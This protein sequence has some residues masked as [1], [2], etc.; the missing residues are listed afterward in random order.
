MIL[1]IVGKG[2]AR[3]SLEERAKNLKIESVKFYESLPQKELVQKYVNADV[4]VLPS[5]FET[6]AIVV[7]EALAAGTPCIV[8]R[9]SALN[10]WIDD[11]TCFGVDYPIRIDELV[12]KINYVFDY[13]ADRDKMKKWI[14]SK[15]VD[16]DYVT[17]KLEKIYNGSL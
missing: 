9:T 7:A 10:E 1:E 5:Q 12:K 17:E 11:E 8:S 6:Y 3:K 4:F 15:I 2:P 14:G 13:F 16:W